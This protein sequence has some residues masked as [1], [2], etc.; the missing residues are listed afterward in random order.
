MAA[1]LRSVSIV[2]PGFA[3]LNTQDSS[4]AL[5]KELTLHQVLTVKNHH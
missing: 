1:E 2:A 4:V 3:G 5:P